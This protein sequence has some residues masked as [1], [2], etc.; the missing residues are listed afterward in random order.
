M[1]R[2]YFLPK[3]GFMFIKQ[4]V[5]IKKFYLTLAMENRKTNQPY[6]PTLSKDYKPTSSIL[7][8]INQK[9]IILNTQKAETTKTQKNKFKP[10]F[11]AS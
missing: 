2:L 11:F 1:V 7:M 10:R 6:Y 9:F 5:K 8:M 3:I 4:F